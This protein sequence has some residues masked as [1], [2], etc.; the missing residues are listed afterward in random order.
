MVIMSMS[1]ADIYAAILR[2]ILWVDNQLDALQQDMAIKNI[3][4][5]TACASAYS[6][7]TTSTQRD[8]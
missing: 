1:I 2:L 3:L 8:W 4:F 6:M 7:F 5:I